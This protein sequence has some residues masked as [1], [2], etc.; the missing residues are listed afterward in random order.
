MHGKLCM[1]THI[2]I[3]SDRTLTENRFTEPRCINRLKAIAVLLLFEL[4]LIIPI[5][6]GGNTVSSVHALYL[7]PRFLGYLLLLRLCSRLPDFFARAKQLRVFFGA[8]LLFE[9]LR[10]F[11]AL[12]FYPQTASILKIAGIISVLAVLGALRSINGGIEHLERSHG[13]ALCARRLNTIWYWL[14][15][16]LLPSLV[17]A[18]V[19]ALRWI[20]GIASFFICICYCIHLSRMICVF[21][22][23]APPQVIEAYE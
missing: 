21:F 9:L 1:S 5:S 19:A 13:I 14:A 8:M 6:G 20:A 7:L 4:E 11:A 22:L 17:F 10:W 16:A 3:N 18:Q 12:L 15:A 23:N 2:A